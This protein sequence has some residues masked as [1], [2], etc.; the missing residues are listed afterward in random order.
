[1][2]TSSSAEE[3]R[4]HDAFLQ[5]PQGED[6]GADG[7]EVLFGLLLETELHGHEVVAELDL[8]AL[9]Q[10]GDALDAGAVH[11]G[12]VLAAEVG[13]G[14]TAAVETN[15]GMHPRQP[16]VGYEDVRVARAAKGGALPLDA[17]AALP[18]RG[19][20]NQLGCWRHA[21]PF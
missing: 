1:M 15:L 21:P 2:R 12:P 9:A 13:D 4:A 20:E 5:G 8:I 18:F 6:P 11:E 16:L 19:L 3:G 10:R 14:E 17:D 7:L